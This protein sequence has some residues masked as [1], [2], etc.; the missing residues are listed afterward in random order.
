MA[1]PLVDERH[2][3]LR[4]LAQ[5]VS[6]ICLSEEFKTLKKELE[7]MYRR[8][9]SESPSTLAFQDALYT[10]LAQEEFDLRRARAF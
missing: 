2:Q 10:L 8:Q 9:G 7:L 4:W 3:E 6:L 5:V 1:L